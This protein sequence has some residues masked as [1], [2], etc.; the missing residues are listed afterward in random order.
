[1]RHKSSTDHLPFNSLRCNKRVQRSTIQARVRALVAKW[2]LS[3]VGTITVSIR[4]GIAWIVDGQHRWL[5]AMEQG[6][7]T[8]KVLCNVYRN[9]TEQEEA[10][11]FLALNDARSVRSVD[12]YFIG[13]IAEDPVCLGARDVL[14][15]YGL[16]ISAGRGD[17]IVR[18]VDEVM[19]IYMRAP[20]VL[21]AVCATITEAWGTR[22]AA[23]ERTLISALDVIYSTYGAELDRGVFAHKLS[24]Y[25]GGP[26][27][28]CGNASGLAD[29]KP[30]SLKRAAAEIMVD[31]YNKGRRTGVIRPL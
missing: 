17:G 8:T 5:A 10:A 2:D 12:K 29:H 13:L 16:R 25:R 23:L 3:Y 15:R 28:L 19:K 11:L 6:L 4:D 21:G 22:P 20:D 31:T 27:A 1:M 7:G 30:I 26:S 24:K 9:L 14:A 18:C